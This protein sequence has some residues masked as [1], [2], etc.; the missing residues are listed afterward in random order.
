MV[1]MAQPA[2]VG[3]L[4]H[5]PVLP[6]IEFVRVRV[7][8]WILGPSLQSDMLIWRFGWS[9]IVCLKSFRT[10]SS[11]HLAVSFNAHMLYCLVRLPAN[12]TMFYE[13]QARLRVIVVAMIVAMILSLRPGQISSRGVDNSTNS[14]S[15]LT[16][17]LLVSYEIGEPAA[18]RQ[19]T[20]TGG[21]PNTNITV[22]TVPKGNEQEMADMMLSLPGV[23]WAEPNYLVYAQAEPN[24]P[25]WPEQWWQHRLET[26][27]AWNVSA[28]S[29]E[30]IVAVLDT[31]ID[32]DHPDRPNLWQN[33]D[34]I[35][36]NGL[37]DD[38]NGKTDDSNGWH[39]WTDLQG[40][41]LQDNDIQ[42]PTEQ[43]TVPTPRAFHGMHVAGIIAAQVNNET[44]IAGVTQGSQIM[45]LRVLDK[46]AI[47]SVLQISQAIHYAVDNGADIIN[48]S[49]GS[50]APSQAMAEAVSYAVEHDVIVV[51][52]A[53]NDGGNLLY[54]AAYPDVI[55]VGGVTAEDK[56][57]SFSNQGIGLDLVAPATDILSTW[58]SSVRGGYHT[59]TGTSM[60]TAEVAGAAALLFALHPDAT[61]DE[62]GQWLTTS[63]LSL[64]EP[65]W[66]PLTGWGRLRIDRAIAAAAADLS[67]LIRTE[68]TRVLPGERIDV[69]I[70]V[71]DEQGQRAGSGLP[72]ELA[73]T[74]AITR[75]LFTDSGSVQMSAF[76]PESLNYGDHF[77]V[78]TS[79]NGQT[80]T[81]SLPVRT[82]PHYFPL[83]FQP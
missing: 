69:E 49:L 42:I 54:P 70:R 37:D 19:A 4:A 50:V 7:S 75:T 79:W 2:A 46:Y 6:P 81:L 20:T 71:E 55:A 47:G 29:D 18:T 35:P 64:G 44:G 60:A 51:A 1:G 59:A 66:D 78:S 10:P 8:F 41:L 80:A 83:L 74:G 9:I 73:A 30:T 12:L 31:G 26:T 43:D 21:I 17:Q 22:L 24:D 65:G 23:R 27:T 72:I 28:G 68:K 53:G 45:P 48:L 57:A 52:A 5:Q 14:Q 63:T 61:P 11:F 34:E 67:L 38:G 62:I 82:L 56:H 58:A 15:F 40:T 25:R 13:N 77:N 32:L 16:G 39:W 36:E 33:P 76:V 3:P